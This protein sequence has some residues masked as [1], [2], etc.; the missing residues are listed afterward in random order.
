M[1][2]RETGVAI[3]YNGEIYNYIE[4]RSEL[5]SRGVRF[6]TSSDTEVLLR[7]YLHWGIECLARLNGMWAF[8][9]W[10]PRESRAYFS[11]DRFGVKPL[12]Y[13]VSDG[14]LWLASEPKAVIAA[15]PWLG[16]VDESAVHDL[17]AEKYVHHDERTFYTRIK[18][19]PPGHWG[20]YSFGDRA[21][22]LTRYWH[23]P[24]LADGNAWEEPEALE[25]FS[26]L[27]TD[28]VRLRLRSDVPVGLTLSGGIDSTAILHSMA[29]IRASVGAG[30]ESYTAVYGDHPAAQGLDERMWARLAASGYDNVALHEV[31]AS[32]D[33]WL[34]TLRRIVWH[35]D[36]PGFSPAVFPM[37][38]IMQRA[39]AQGVPVLLEGQGADELFGG[40]SYYAALAFVDRLTERTW[41]FARATGALGAAQA[42]IRA[43][44]APRF[45]RD[46]AAAVLP[47]ARDW[48][49]RRSTLRPALASSPAPTWRAG[50]PRPE[51][52][53]RCERRLH[54]DFARVRLPAFLQYGDAVSMAHSIE[55]RLP[56]LDYR[57]VEFGMR[58]PPPARIW[59]GDTKRL[60]RQHLRGVG[61]HEIADRRDKRG[62]PTPAHDWLAADHGAVLR[63][64]LLDRDARIRPM[65]DSAGLERVI[66]RHAAGGYSAGDALYG[67]L[68]TELW[69]QQ[70]PAR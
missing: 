22:S 8:V 2:D 27:L 64:L 63:E 44:S 14:A 34:D 29:G 19:I 42:G 30:V 52:A 68:A 69:W 48:E 59:A 51:V 17:L 15:C 65:I 3:T 67:L 54:S 23:S 70:E 13:A 45:A 33:A 58:L 40:Y 39:R 57:L 62:Y 12:Y 36:G 53:G 7:S 21:P 20:A 41:P 66:N 5:Q 55:T 49:R 31:E 25:R 28:A 35:M 37:W 61:Q 46:V 6:A 56:F 26:T 4:L 38:M 47:P 9:L 18:S 1:V 32:N 24:A 43:G 10:D 11:R 50:E 60:L 16:Q